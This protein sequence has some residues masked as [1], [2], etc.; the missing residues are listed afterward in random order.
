VIEI[1][2]L[3]KAYGKV[4]AVD[5]LSL[6]V[7][8][9]QTFGLLGPNGAGK[10]TL[11]H[12]LTGALRPDTGSIRLLGGAAA[13]DRSVRRKIGL[14]P[15]ALAIYDGLTAAENLAF[16]GKLYGLSGT[17][18][19]QRIDWA[20]DIAGLR[21]RPGDRVRTYSGG[22]KRRLNLACALVHDP[23]VL[24]LDEPTAGVDPQSR[25]H[26][27][28][29]ISRLA[30]QGRTIIYTTHY[31]EEA[32]RVCQHVAIMD[33]GKVL[34]TDSVD[35]LIERFGGRSVIEAELAAPPA[36]PVAGR[37]EGNHLH[38]ETEQPFEEVARLAAAGLRFR[39]LEIVRPNLE[40]V[41]LSLT[42]RSLRD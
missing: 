41:F 7:A 23:E 22:M 12:L 40:T 14:A 8:P 38:L 21:E 31:I 13:T 42:G 5:H 35:G 36:E 11:I 39:H 24:F 18:L 2:D 9:G 29:C 25:N 27:L 15:Q 28:E 16:F 1:R 17:H 4:T 30:G 34:A 26:L 20:L 6:E 3:C 10:T 32:E 33:H 19:R 37:V